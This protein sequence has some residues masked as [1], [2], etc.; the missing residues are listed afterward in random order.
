MFCRR[1]NCPAI[2]FPEM[3]NALIDK[4]NPRSRRLLTHFILKPVPF[5]ES[6]QPK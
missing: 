6:T 4:N 5:G 2:L 1:V 3:L